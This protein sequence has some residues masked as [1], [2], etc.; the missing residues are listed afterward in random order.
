MAA[1][2]T[3]Q[4]LIRLREMVF[5]GELSPDSNHYEADLADQLGM[6]RTPVREAALTMQAQG[7]VEVQPRRGVRILPISAEDMAEIYDVLCELESLAAARAAEKSYTADDLRIAQVCIDNMDTA[8]SNQDRDAWAS[9]DDRFHTELVRLGG[10]ARVAEIVARYTDQVRRA[11]MM[12]LPLRPL[13]VQSN[14]D[15]R[16]VL[17]AI[18]NRDA[19]SARSLHRAHRQQA[20]TLLTGLIREF[21]LRRL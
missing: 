18:E 17:F 4:A 14:E 15:H 7:L 21:G 9:A 12:T 8:L 19:Q 10:N 3:N 1:S 16:A 6:S 5:T 20:S 13:P 11:R 2:Q